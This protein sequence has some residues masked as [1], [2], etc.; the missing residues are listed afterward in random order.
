MVLR[1]VGEY[2][3][4]EDR[5]SANG[6]NYSL[7]KF[8]DDKGTQFSFYVPGNAQYSVPTVQ[9]NKGTVYDLNFEYIHNDFQNRNELQLKDIISEHKIK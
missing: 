5:Q 4:R 3:G 8:E 9:L 7:C 2:R 1:G 6:T